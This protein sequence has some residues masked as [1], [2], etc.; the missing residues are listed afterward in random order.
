MRRIEVQGGAKEGQTAQ[1]AAAA[2]AATAA[3]AEEEGEEGEG[4]I[5]IDISVVHKHQTH[6]WI[7]AD[8]C[9]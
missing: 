9:E 6:V 7:W 5:A 8:V 1:A 3:E 4:K 2:T